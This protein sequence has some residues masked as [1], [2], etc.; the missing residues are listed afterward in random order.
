M[1]LLLC[2]V[3]SLPWPIDTHG[4]KISFYRNIVQKI[5]CVTW[6]QMI[7]VHWLNILLLIKIKMF[8]CKKTK[9]NCN[10]CHCEN[11]AAEWWVAT[12][13]SST[14]VKIRLI[15]VFYSIFNKTVSDRFND[16]SK[17][18]ISSLLMQN[19]FWSVP[20]LRLKFNQESNVKA[21]TVCE[22]MLKAVKIWE[23]E[24]KVQRKA[25]KKY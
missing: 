21:Q 9:T 22:N 1:Y 14:D 20:V 19:L 3:M 13:G 12:S 7:D 8:S 5:L 17:V 23:I 25:Q 4:P 6:A 11:N 16:R 15:F 10:L 2:F 18:F 24:L